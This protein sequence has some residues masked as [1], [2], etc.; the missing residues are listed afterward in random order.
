MN[1][2]SNGNGAS[3]SCAMEI[4]AACGGDEDMP[5]CHH[6][7]KTPLKCSNGVVMCDDDE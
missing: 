6:D 3:P 1:Y 2:D 5:V 7:G 4:S